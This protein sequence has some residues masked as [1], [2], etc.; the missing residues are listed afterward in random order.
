MFNFNNKKTQKIVIGIIVGIL[1]ICMVLP[2]LT[3]IL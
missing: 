1:V 3:Y 2:L